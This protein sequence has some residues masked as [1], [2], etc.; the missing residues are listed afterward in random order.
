[1]ENS[2]DKIVKVVHLTSAHQDGDVRIFHKECVSLAQAGFEVYHLIPNT[3]SRIE[4]GVHIVSFDFP[5]TSRFKRMFFLVKEIYKK[6]L[7]LNADIYHLHDPELLRI[8]MKLKKKGKKVIY[9]S[10]EDLPRD[11]LSKQYI[12]TFLRK[13]ICKRVE[14]FENRIASRIDG[15]VTATP[16]IRDRFLK[17]QKNTV[18]INNYPV[19]ETEVPY[20]KYEEKTVNAICYI[21]TLNADRG[22]REIVQAAEL[23]NCKLFLGGDFR[24]AGFK[25]ELQKLEGWKRVEELGFLNREQVLDVYNKS[26]LGLVTL[27]PLINFMDALPVKMFEYMAAGIPVI[28]SN[29]PYWKNI[30]EIG[31]CGLCVDPKSPQEIANAIKFILENPDKAKV[32]SENGKR[33]VKEVSNWDIEKKKL[34]EFYLKLNC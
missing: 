30:V 9:D 34:V 13:F 8:A 29:F 19:L 20:L 33:L 22:V 15:V 21:G 11:I 5:V 6:A 7:A 1:M 12:P 32:M 2:Q 24:Q 18:D 3:K 26:K 14:K 10:H 31:E 28:A 23:A 4:K 16:F 27:H 17:I 25:E